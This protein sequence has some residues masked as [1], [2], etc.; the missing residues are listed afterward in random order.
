MAGDALR[1]LTASIEFDYDLSGLRE[2]DSLMDDVMRNLA[3][4]G[5]KIDGLRGDLADLGRRGSRDIDELGDAADDAADDIDDLADRIDE[6]MDDI[7]DATRDAQDEIDDLGDGERLNG[8]DGMLGRLFGALGDLIPQGA[9]AGGAMSAMAVVGVAAGAAIV[10]AMV[11]VGVAIAAVADKTDQANDKMKAMIGATTEETNDMKEAA[12]AVYKDGWGESYES[13]AEDIANLKGDFRDLN[14]GELTEFGKKAN[15]IKDVWGPE[16]KEVSAAVAGL[17][18]NFEGLSKSDALDLITTGFQKGGSKASEDLLDT[19]NEYSVFF[20]KMGMSAEDFTGTL[21]KGLQAGARNT[22]VVA[23]AFKEFGIKAIDGSKTTIAGYEA[24]GFKADEMAAKIA[25]GGPEA[26]SAFNAVTAALSMVKD[27]TE[28]N[29]IGVELFGTKWEDLREDVILSMN[30]AGDAVEGF[31]GATERAGDDLTDN[32]GSKMHQ[33]GREISGAFMEAIQDSGL[34]DGMTQAAQGIIDALPGIIASFQEA[35]NWIVSIFADEDGSMTGT[36]QS[37]M[38]LFQGAADLIMAVWGAMAPYLGPILVDGLKTAWAI[39]SGVL[40]AIGSLFSVAASLIKG[41]WSGAWEAIKQLFSNSLDNM[42]NIGRNLLNLLFDVFNATLGKLYTAITG[43][44]LTQAGKDMIQGLINGISNMAGAA[45]AKVKEV[46]SNIKNTLIEFF[47]IHSPSRVMKE[48]GG[49]ISQG[50]AV[51][52]ESDAGKAIDSAQYLGQSV[53]EAV[54]APSDTNNPYSQGNG[55][56][57]TSETPQANG[58]GGGGVSIGNATFHITVER[59]ADGSAPD[60]NAIVRALESY[61][62]S[63]AASI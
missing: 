14:A 63:L 58:G 52:I 57:S 59:G 11:G 4:L 17:T 54:V 18:R 36:M 5:T 16:T 43:V 31:R 60:E 27:E 13:I 15:I 49:F 10:G 44:D 45:V 19:F 38:T 48:L 28:Q 53:Q 1:E 62:G 46:G 6:N 55:G 51:G 2:I 37:L 30:N 25:K 7:E 61:F 26:K 24:L 35:W 42:L 34:A 20:S 3:D 23:D 40:S 32:F 9:L 50:M 33:V 56:S 21:I 12:L 29:A 39:A 41:D 22:D 47:D 8:L